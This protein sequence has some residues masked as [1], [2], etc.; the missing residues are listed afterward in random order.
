MNELGKVIEKYYIVLP[1]DSNM[2]NSVVEIGV[3]NSNTITTE[4]ISNMIQFINFVIESRNSKRSYLGY[5]NFKHTFRP[6]ANLFQ[7]YQQ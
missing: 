5:G 2:L 7:F 1:E 3:T 4:Q 6:M